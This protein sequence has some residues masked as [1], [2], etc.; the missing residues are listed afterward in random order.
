MILFAN[1]A[2]PFKYTA[3]GTVKRQLTLSKYSEEILKLYSAVEDSTRAEISAPPSWD[4]SSA[5]SFVRDVVNNVL[6]KD[7]N[8]A[9]DLFENGCDSLHTIW[10]CNTILRSL[11]DSTNIET[12]QIPQDF[13]YNCPSVNSLTDFVLGI[14]Q[15]GISDTARPRDNEQAM[16]SLVEKYSMEIQIVP[17]VDR[18]SRDGKCVLLTGSTGSFGTYLLADLIF[19]ASISRVY[20][21][22]RTKTN[23]SLERRQRKAFMEKGIDGDL[24]K[25][26]KLKLI[27][28]DFL[29]PEFGISPESYKE[30]ENTVTHVIHNAWPVNFNL[31]LSSFEPNLQGVRSLL[32]FSMRSGAHFT[33]ISTIGV[34]QNAPVDHHPFKEEP[35]PSG[36][37]LGSGYAESKWVAEQLFLESRRRAGLKGQIVRAGQLCGNRANG[38]WN[39]QEW[40]PVM[41]QSAKR[42]RGYRR[43][44]IESRG[45][46]TQFRCT[47]P[48]SASET[49]SNNYLERPGQIHRLRTRRGSRPLQKWLEWLENA[50]REDTKTSESHYTPFLL[51]FYRSMRESS[52]WR[53]AFGLPVIDIEK[54]LKSCSSVVDPAVEELGEE[55]VHRW[56]EY[57]KGNEAS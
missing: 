26:E 33:F 28:G 10:I 42:S 27:E 8:D 52:E 1:P 19:D 47:G 12:R 48:N 57:W 6:K 23:E 41:I 3:K 29:V 5:K 9:D 49:P 18:P 39:R 53:E 20:A 11:R 7:T 25:S 14:V 37:A 17:K 43:H 13:V 32:D 22:N 34:F 4:E 55:D 45:R 36:S 15:N 21:L 31:R 2:K 44:R 50:V 51:P 56:L 54:A 38:S 35:V 30:M 24:L 40:A 16:L 46:I